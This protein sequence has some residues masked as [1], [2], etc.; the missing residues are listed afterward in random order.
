MQ[1]LTSVENVEGTGRML[2]QEPEFC[3][4]LEVS[5][6]TAAQCGLKQ[7]LPAGKEVAACCPCKRL[8]TFHNICST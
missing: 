2:F 5:M 6:H 4:F 3:A 7:S 8:N 1:A